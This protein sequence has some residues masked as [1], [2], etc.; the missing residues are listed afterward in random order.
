MLDAIEHS[1]KAI[2]L[3]E[4][5]G[6]TLIDVEPSR[7]SCRDQDCDGAQRDQQRCPVQPPRRAHHGRNRRTMSA[8]FDARVSRNGEPHCVCQRIEIC[9]THRVGC[10]GHR[11]TT[12]RHRKGDFSCQRLERARNEGQ[13]N[14]SIAAALSVLSDGRP[15][16]HEYRVVT[17]AGEEGKPRH[18]HRHLPR[19]V[20]RCVDST[21]Q[22]S[23]A[24]DREV[25]SQ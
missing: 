13:Q 16:V 21:C 11:T 20:V 6:W 17:L 7:Q 2:E 1:S 18:G 3:Y 10:D 22:L 24:R 14:Q 4:R 15:I 25:L 8:D 19:L 9:R 5:T 23:T 12:R